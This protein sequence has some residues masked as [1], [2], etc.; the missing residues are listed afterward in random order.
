[1]ELKQLILILTRWFWLL[2]LGIVLGASAGILISRRQTPV[3]QATAKILVMRVPD[4]SAFGLAYLGNQQLAQTF[5]ELITTQPV[6]DAASNSLGFVF[7]PS[8]VKIQQDPNSQII[9]VIVE[10]SDPQRTASIANA[11][12]ASSITHYVDLQV[13]QYTGVEEDLQSQLN[14]LQTRIFSMQTHISET[15]TTILNNQKQQI[16]SIM[17]PMQQE[18]AQL[19]QD[20]ALQTPGK[21]PVT[22]AQAAII[23][24][25]QSRLDEI[26]PLLKVYQD[27]YANLVVLNQPIADGSVDEDTLVL[28]KKTLESVQQ[29]YIDLTS[30][31]ELLKQAHSSGVSNVTKI[32]DASVPDNPVSPQVLINILLTAAGGFI[33]A[34]IAVFLMENL[35]IN[36]GMP[37]NM[38]KRV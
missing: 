3:Y 34:V 23:A 28:L 33:L 7:D 4:T 8:Q 15:T 17:T 18:V 36:L 5:T 6:F 25:K 10:D 19:Q 11:L 22:P 32:Q 9:W 30:K 29:N 27:A 1:M 26:L 16:L 21:L 31:L 24:A 20:I 35:D 38:R 13:G 14:F 2:I 37:R 12:V